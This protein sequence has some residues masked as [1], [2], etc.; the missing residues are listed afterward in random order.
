MLRQ[1]EK[2]PNEDQNKNAYK[3]M[4]MSPQSRNKRLYDEAKEESI[5][6][7]L[8]GQHSKSVSGVAFEQT[9]ASF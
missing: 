1:V 6:N 4:F 3:Q 9:K 2:T 8:N 7:A 5:S